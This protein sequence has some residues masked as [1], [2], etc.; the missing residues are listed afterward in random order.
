MTDLHTHI[1]P[2][3]D[4]GARSAE[5]SVAMLRLERMQGVKAVVLTPHFYGAR[6]RAK[7][8][9][10]RRDVAIKT[11]DDELAKLSQEE[12]DALPELIP[13]AEVAWH[14]ALAGCEEL[15]QLCIGATKN[16]LLELPFTPW[17]TQ[18]FNQIY[19]LIGETGLTPVIA[20][21]ERY[22]RF[23]R[24]RQ[25]GEIFELGVPV[26]ISADTLKWPLL[27]GKVLRLFEEQR[28]HILASDCH[29]CT[30]R[31]PNVGEGLR[32][33]RRK[34]GNWYADELVRCADELVG[35]RG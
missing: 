27:R 1:L 2:G 18:M 6:E 32:M 7:D 19:D 9:L 5:E 31:S 12:R 29:N 16:F 8:F 20:H 4:D 21:L 11:L 3:M 15:P 22:V 23:Q 33:I 25:I 14:S 10:R 34:L 17:S 28:A 13:A 24:P 35:L 30:D 26:Q